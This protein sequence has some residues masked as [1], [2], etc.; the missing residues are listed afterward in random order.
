MDLKRFWLLLGDL[1][2]HELCNCVLMCDVIVRY[3]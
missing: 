3:V 1:C 2:A